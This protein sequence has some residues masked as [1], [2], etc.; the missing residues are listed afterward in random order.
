MHYLH[1]RL[2]IH[3]ITFVQNHLKINQ[4][5]IYSYRSYSKLQKTD[6]KQTLATVLIIIQLNNLRNHKVMD[7][8]AV[9]SR[10]RTRESTECTETIISNISTQWKPILCSQAV[11]L[12]IPSIY[13]HG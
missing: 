8:K 12:K 10:W 4:G 1:D 2:T 7:L 3:T 13:C 9:T 11:L 6:H 5:I